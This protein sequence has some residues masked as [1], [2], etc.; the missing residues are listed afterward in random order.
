M[1][2]NIFIKDEHING[3]EDWAQGPPSI[4]LKTIHRIN[5][6]GMVADDYISGV[7]IPGNLPVGGNISAWDD[8]CATLAH[9]QLLSQDSHHGYDEYFRSCINYF[10]STHQKMNIFRLLYLHK[11]VNTVCKKSTIVNELQISRPHVYK[12]LKECEEAEYV[13][14]IGNG[15]A[16]TRHAF[17][18]FRCYSV[19]WWNAN[20]ETGLSAQFFRVFHSRIGVNVKDKLRKHYRRVNK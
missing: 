15:V 16:L 11:H 6:I 8:Y 12:T 17:D 18:A 10:R 20:V 2:K 5:S 9:H 19:N 13:E 14:V 3:D 1:K 4:D 7:T